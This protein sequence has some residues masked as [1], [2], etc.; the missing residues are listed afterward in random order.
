[1]LPG[2]GHILL[3]N[4]IIRFK[5]NKNKSDLVTNNY[6]CEDVHEGKTVISSSL[7]DTALPN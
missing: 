6:W 3:K 5:V 2:Q 4:I 7:C 1:M